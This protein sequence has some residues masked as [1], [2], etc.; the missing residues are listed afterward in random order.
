MCPNLRHWRCLSWRFFLRLYEYCATYEESAG[1]A[2]RSCPSSVWPV[3]QGVGTSDAA[4]SDAQSADNSQGSGTDAVV[5]SYGIPVKV[6]VNWDDPMS[7]R[8]KEMRDSARSLIAN[9]GNSGKVL[10]GLR[11]P[12]PSEIP[13]VRF[14]QPYGVDVGVLAQCLTEAGFPTP[15]DGDGGLRVKDSDLSNPQYHLA[16]YRCTG[17]YPAAPLA[18]RPL[19]PDQLRV[20]YDYLINTVIPCLTQ[21]GYP[22]TRPVPSFAVWSQRENRIQEGAGADGDYWDAW[23]SASPSDRK[24]VKDL[25]RKCPRIALSQLWGQAEV[26]K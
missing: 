18:V 5:D 6:Q 21:N 14:R 11:F 19:G 7:V 4:S 25:L 16:S 8:S 3:P 1:A 15:D 10:A 23:L 24:M 26:A 9:V 22:Q 13:F 12:Q 2:V 17:M 20:H